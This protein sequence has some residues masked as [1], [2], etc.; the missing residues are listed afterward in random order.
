MIETFP[1]LFFRLK[2]MFP[3][4]KL[5]LLFDLKYAFFIR[6]ISGWYPL[7]NN[8]KTTTFYW[9]L[10]LSRRHV[11]QFKNVFSFNSTM[12]LRVIRWLFL[13]I[14]HL[15]KLRLK[16]FKIHRWDDT[17][18]DHMTQSLSFEICTLLSPYCLI[19]SMPGYVLLTLWAGGPLACHIQHLY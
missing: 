14:L 12:T 8:N 9:V 16:E 7:I 19:K 10:T 4:I 1:K 15:N 11:N 6:E 13:S 17:T 5:F 3:L 2:K 18:I